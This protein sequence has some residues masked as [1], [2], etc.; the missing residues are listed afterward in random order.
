MNEKI[1]FVITWVD[2]NDKEWQDEKK[3]YS[4]DKENDDAVFRYRD[5]D[6]LKY[7][8]R[9]VEKFAPWVNN[10]YFVTCGH[11]P[12]WLNLKNEKLKIVKHSDFMPEQ[13]LPTFSSHSIE[14]NLYKI[15]NLSENF[16]Y[17]NDDMFLINT[18]KDTDFFKNNIP[19][20]SAVLSPYIPT[21]Y[22]DLSILCWNMI[23]IINEHYN[24]NVQIKRNFFKWFNFKYGTKLIRTILM[25]TWP[26]FSGFYETHM[27]NS[28]HKT[29]FE[30]VWK[31]ENEI[32]DNTC[33]EKFRNLK[34]HVNQWI[35][36]YWQLAKGDFVPRN[37][38]LSK[39]FDLSNDNYYKIERYISSQRGKI[40]CLNDTNEVDNFDNK[41]NIL[42]SSFEKI[43]PEK[44]SFEKY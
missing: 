17:F 41:K 5:W 31:K 13:Y 19:C 38:K 24:K 3:K 11:Y 1:D 7:W 34:T 26:R 36:R 21:Q 42:K 40:I 12:Q 4:P 33:V 14:L 22:D 29:T 15:E 8:F 9:G 43:L 30:D 27:P 39:Y 44:S 10:I 6:L 2:G 25:I 35:F 20:D 16:V 23:G 37:I 18:V 28:F 32:L